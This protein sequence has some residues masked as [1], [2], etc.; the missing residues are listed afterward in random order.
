MGIGTDALEIL[1]GLKG[2]GYLAGHT[3]IIEIGAQQLANSFLEA[4]CRGG[5]DRRWLDPIRPAL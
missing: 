5:D 2:Q 4:R 1:I 3:S